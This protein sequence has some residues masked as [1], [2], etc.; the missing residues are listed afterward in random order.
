MRL[1]R[2]TQAVACVIATF[3]LT[4]CGSDSDNNT[5][6]DNTSPSLTTDS[7][8]VDGSSAIAA[9]FVSGQVQDEGGIKSLTYTQNDNPTQAIALDADGS[10]DDSISL[11]LGS[12][13]II[14]EATDKAGNVTRSTKTIYLGDT[15]AAGGAHTAALRDGQLY[16][17]GRN[18]Y[19]QT[20]LGLTTRFSDAMGHPSTPML[21]NSAPENLL[22]ISFNQNHS[23]AIDQT[24][25]VY[26]WGEDK[27][28]QLG[29]GDIGRNDCSGTEDC[30]LDISAIAGIE[31]AVMVAAGYG[32][33]LVLTEDGSVWAFGYNAQGQLGDGT[34]TDSST[35]VE[36][37]F[38]AATNIGRIVQVVASANSSYALDDKGQVWGWGS[39]M[40][41][42]LGKGTACTTANDC[43]NVNAQPVLIDV[44]NSTSATDSSD[45]SATTEVE[46][47]T[48]LAAGRDHVL[49]LTNQESV[50]GWGLNASS[51][52]GYNGDIYSETESAW[53]LTITAP[54][55][56]TWFTDKE[57]RRVYANGNSSYVLL[58]DVDTENGSSTDG[59]L[60]A[61]G[62]FG[63]T[64]S[65]GITIYDDLD[66]P[67]NKLPNLEDIE[68]MAMG[69]LHHIAN[70]ND[71]E[72]NDTDEEQN[73]DLF[74]WGWSFEG[75]LGNENTTN[76]WMY[77]NPIPVT[78]PSQL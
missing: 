75:S 61:W 22:S 20:G 67:T 35:P 44:L 26:S 31:N 33:N 27:D 45:T 28:G 54:T 12:N 10:F 52:V 37:D 32:H 55:K 39:D 3:A 5:V 49:A 13:T 4:A 11:D 14:L 77:N 64:N 48:Q 47:V 30:R 40:Y 15:I 69:A 7:N 24:G 25:Q 70:D 34:S 50:Y 78:L 17:W 51:Q 9:A 21:M 6:S 68:N 59:A 62:V 57:V 60:Y 43:I 74:T 76:F 58:D 23:L 19:G 1:N 73:E 38:S 46:K 56:L 2:L 29:R 63:E 72:P 8:F 42:N 36:V 66:E 53:D 18:N 65:E 41:A 16:G 71:F